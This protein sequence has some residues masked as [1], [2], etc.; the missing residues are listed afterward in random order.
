[1]PWNAK[2][3]GAYAIESTE[4]LENITVMNGIFN[5]MGYVTPAQAGI[6]GNMVH[7]SG[8]N[9]WRW[10]SDSVNRNRGYGLF[11]F[12]PAYPYTEGLEGTGT[13][14]WAP[15]LST[16]SV[17]PGAEP[18]DG[19]AQLICFNDDTFGKWTTSC[20]RSYWDPNS[21]PE[22]YSM[23]GRIL[24]D[25]GNGSRLYLDDFKKITDIQDATFAFLACYEGPSVPNYSVRVADALKIYTHLNGDIPPEPEP[26]DKKRKMPL[27]FYL[28]TFL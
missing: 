17:T 10:E 23:R 26:G 11:Q 21:Y 14:Y 2:P 6:M 16:T 7:E 8:L 9:P 1:M 5:S 12:T 13:P 3:A 20:W 27:Y 4:G 18:S 24:T 28:R 22:L 25:W 19:H 15:N